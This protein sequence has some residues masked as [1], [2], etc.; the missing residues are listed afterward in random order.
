MPGSKHK[1]AF[2]DFQTPIDLAR[3]V[4][5]A[6]AR[7]G[8]R[9][10][11]I[12]EPTCGTGSLLLAALDEFPS[13]RAAVGLD[14]NQQYVREARDALTGSPNRSKVRLLA[15]NFFDTA[16]EKILRSLPDPLLVIGNLPWV[17]SAVLGSLGSR[18]LPTK[19]NFQKHRGLD[20]ITGKSNF[21]ISEWMML[22]ILDWL[23]GRQ[24][25]LA[26]LCKTA[27]A[28]KVLA[29][30]WRA[31]APL[32]SSAT[33]I[34]PAFL[35]FG[36]AVDACLLVCAFVPGAHSS[37]CAVYEALA[38]RAPASRIGLRNNQLIANIELYERWKH[39]EGRERRKWRSGIKHDC[40]QV[41]ELTK[42]DSH[43]RNR[44]GEIVD[45]EDTYVYPMLKS[46]DLANGKVACPRRWML[47]PQR[48][49]GEST[50]SIKHVA[51]KTWAYLTRNKALFA[52]RASSIYEGRPP[53]SI[54]GVGEYSFSPWKV[55]ISGFYKHLSFKVV[56]PFVSRPVV[57][58]DTSYFL[59]CKTRHEAEYLAGL[60]NSETARGFYEAFVFWDSKRPVTVDLLRRLD[61]LALASALGRAS[62][63]ARLFS[64]GKATQAELAL[65]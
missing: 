40:A 22:R 44:A 53:F 37:D 28:R 7:T 61:L 14:I 56:G 16:W 4:C 27:V 63:A 21:D 17:T 24:A 19:S 41:L 3:E 45:I 47:V 42:E 55:A 9:P 29:H 20:A 18:N 12:L 30:A 58:D 64:D 62:F 32:A 8:L 38:S 10:R 49:I 35:H 1:V 43:Y 57:L 46:S 2:G 59:P 11:S 13:A 54:F 34:I 23:S 65:N 25:T 33:Y 48:S 52:R 6:V 31:H 39:L 15:A 36:A 26:L 51:P 5:S 60:L 50:A